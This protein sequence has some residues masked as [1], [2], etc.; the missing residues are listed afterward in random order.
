MHALFLELDAPSQAVVPMEVDAPSQALVPM[1]DGLRKRLD[2]RWKKSA[3]RWMRRVRASRAVLNAL[4]T[5]VANE[6]LTFEELR[7]RTSALAG[8]S[9]ETG[10][11]RAFFQKHAFR[12]LRKS[13]RRTR[14]RRKRRC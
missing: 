2:S 5:L 8:V 12:L 11:G 1:S 3:L 10:A 9:L 6:Q 7:L 13:R 4:R 14:A